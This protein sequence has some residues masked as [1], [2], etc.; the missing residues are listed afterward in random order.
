M[1]TYSD[2][3]RLGSVEAAHLLL[4]ASLMDFKDAQV[5]LSRGC[6]HSSKVEAAL[7]ELR[8]EQPCHLWQDSRLVHF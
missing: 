4:T 6:W 8:Q 3:M 1:E 5:R 7:G 2:R